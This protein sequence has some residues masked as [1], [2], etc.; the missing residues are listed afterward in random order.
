MAF[1]GNFV[2][3]AFKLAQW[4]AGVNFATGTFKLALYTDAAELSEGTTAY[5]PAGEVVAAGYPT[6]GVAL[7]VSLQ[8]TAA[9]SVV[10]MSFADAVVTAALTARGALVYQVGGPALFGLDFGADKT[11]QSTFTV[12][13]PPAVANTA[14][15]RLE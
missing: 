7:T 12:Q 4:G 15:L 10:Y 9:G 2:C 14:I 8:P 5:T 6:G 1:K 13:F 11:S 3:N